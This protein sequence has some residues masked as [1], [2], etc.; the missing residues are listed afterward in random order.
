ML[1]NALI[2][3]LDFFRDSSPSRHRFSGAAAPSQSFC[4]LARAELDW[5]W[6]YQYGLAL[7][8]LSIIPL[9]VLGNEATAA[10]VA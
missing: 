6:G 5:A 1:A 8:V 10:P 3:I 2:A 7:I 4:T 9:A